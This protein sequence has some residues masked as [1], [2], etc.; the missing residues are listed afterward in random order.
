MAFYAS[1]S[2]TAPIY[3]SRKSALQILVPWL[4]LVLA[5]P[6]CFAFQGFQGFDYHPVFVFNGFTH[7]MG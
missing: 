6:F 7:T 5:F 3:S 4:Y 1:S 2:Q